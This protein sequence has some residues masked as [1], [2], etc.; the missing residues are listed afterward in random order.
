MATYPARGIPNDAEVIQNI[1]TSI[2]FLVLNFALLEF[3][4]H[5]IAACV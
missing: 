5:S 3:P 4:L 2:G 1:S